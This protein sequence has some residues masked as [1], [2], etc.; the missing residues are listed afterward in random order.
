MIWRGSSVI[1][2]EHPI[3]FRGFS[4]SSWRHGAVLPTVMPTTAART[5]PRTSVSVPDSIDFMD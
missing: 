3:R 1:L 2:I 4:G 5:V